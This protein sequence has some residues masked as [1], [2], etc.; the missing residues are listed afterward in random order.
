LTSVQ[1]ATYYVS[2]SQG[3]DSNSGLSPSSPF[4][5]LSKVNSLQLNPGDEVLF[6][7]GDKWAE[8][9][10]LVISSSGAQGSPIILDAYGSGSKPEIS[11]ERN[12]TGT[13]TN[14]GGNIWRLNISNHNS[15]QRMLWLDDASVKIIGSNYDVWGDQVNG[16][17]AVTSNITSAIEVQTLNSQYRWDSQD[18][19]IDLYST[20]DPGTTYKSIQTYYSSD[21]IHLINADYITIQDIEIIKC[22]TAI[23]VQGSSNVVIDNCEVHDAYYHAVA[24][25]GNGN[26]KTN[27][28]EIKNCSFWS[29]FGNM[30]GGPY[31]YYF[32]RGNFGI[33]FQN[34]VDYMKVHNNSIM[35]FDHSGILGFSD[36]SSSSNSINYNEFYDNIID[37]TGVNFGRAFQINGP[38]DECHD[39]RYYRNKIIHQNIYSELAGYN[40]YFYYNVFLDDTIRGHYL[41]GEQQVFTWLGNGYANS[42]NYFFN[43]TIYNC[44]GGLVLDWGAQNSMFN[45]LIINYNKEY[46][47]PVIEL[48]GKIGNTVYQNNL[49][50]STYVNH[51]LNEIRYNNWL[52]T[53]SQWNSNDMGGD[54]ISGN[55]VISSNPVMDDNSFKLYPSN[56]AIATGIDISSYV[57]S[58]F[59]KD[60]DGNTINKSNPNIGAVDNE[61]ASNSIP[62][63]TVHL[64]TNIASLAKGQSATLSW[65][66]QNADQLDLEP[67]VGAVNPQGSITVNPQ[68]TTKY[69]IT[70]KGTGGTVSSSVT[71]TVTAAAS[72]APT[73]SLT[74]SSTNINLG[75]SVKLYWVSS[76]AS[77]LNLQP[78]IGSV[79]PNDSV[80]VTPQVTTTYAI[81]AI[82]NNDTAYSKITVNVITSSS[83][84]LSAQLTVDKS[85]IQKGSPV[86]LSWTSQNA[87]NV[88]ITPG[89]GK[90]STNGS[91]SVTP[92]STTTYSLTASDGKNSVVSIARVI[93]SNSTSEVRIKIF[94]QGA[95][96]DNDSMFTDLNAN[97]LLPDKQPYSVS[98]WNYKGSES[99]QSFPS[100]I[101]DWV[102]VQL[103]TSESSSST[104][105]EQAALL[106]NDGIITDING[107]DY[108]SFEN[109]PTGQAGLT[110]AKYYIVVKH[111]NHLPVMSS[112]TV[113]FSSHIVVN[114]D[115]N[116][117]FYDFTNSP[118]KAYGN[119]PTINLG[120]DVYGM[121]GGDANADGIINN[122]DITYIGS[123]VFQ[124]GYYN[125]DVDMNGKINV[126]DYKL[127]TH[128][129][130][131]NTQISLSKLINNN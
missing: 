86:I 1:A 105:A 53:I 93:V 100:N 7:R 55:K 30:A 19:Y 62:V 110:S 87:A 76:N 69:T 21:G 36:G 31:E 88:S 109:L 118:N 10:G 119:N 8:G 34:G 77:K 71:I 108:L 48:K 125:A 117:V 89:I 72:A 32:D 66:S 46:I 111:R 23:E 81:D 14:I 52:G 16:L 130:Q 33:L 65:S 95:Y 47:T 39:N 99:V 85:V 83:S 113:A 68:S 115:Q 57:P 13:W 58:S 91:Q 120:N 123:F 27:Y 61:S 38:Q 40:N 104:V 94:L 25:E 98:P 60:M 80:I 12:L 11:L 73:V 101:V 103:R 29:G 70:A 5:T 20:T 26:I 92:D 24:A 106:R 96:N 54:I 74:A 82:Q 107:N 35:N 9:I 44:G 41:E 129:S 49:F 2:S 126:L 22:P 97:G 121:Y 84:A 124:N 112:S 90:V 15:S 122:D 42:N 114:S 18:G 50:Y 4:A 102:L 63:P 75:Q 128:N 79:N 17:L 64:S 131:V 67:G 59:T 56:D 116:L 3:N 43:N 45:N 51:N 28:L 37:F 6:N 78:N 127:P